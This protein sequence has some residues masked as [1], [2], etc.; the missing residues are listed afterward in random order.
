LRINNS[1]FFRYTGNLC[2]N[3]F[4]DLYFLVANSAM[5]WNKYKPFIFVRS[6]G[7]VVKLSFNFSVKFNRRFRWKGNIVILDEP[8]LR[9]FNYVF[10][11]QRYLSLFSFHLS[12][13]SPTRHESIETLANTPWMMPLLFTDIFK[14]LSLTLYF[15]AL[16]NPDASSL[17]NYSR[18]KRDQWPIRKWW[19]LT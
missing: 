16:L 14:S 15:F 9:Y 2:R 17:L 1:G 18:S 7:R 5:N 8:S 13:P 3:L 19:F 4:H 10:L 12:R 6:N 11:R